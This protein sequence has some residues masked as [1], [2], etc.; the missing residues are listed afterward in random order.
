MWKCPFSTETFFGLNP[1]DSKS[2]LDLE[3]EINFL[4]FFGKLSRSE[5]IRMP[6]WKRKQWVEWTVENLKLIYGTD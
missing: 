1:K 2:K 4:V 5:A 6:R 3:K